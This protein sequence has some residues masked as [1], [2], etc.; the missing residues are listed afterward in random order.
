MAGNLLAIGFI[1]LLAMSAWVTLSAR[2]AAMARLRQQVQAQGFTIERVTPAAPNV[3][4]YLNDQ[5]GRSRY[6]SRSAF[7]VIVSD[8]GVHLKQVWMIENA[9]VVRI[10]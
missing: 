4:T 10:S 8:H 2:R 3:L 1:L 6:V 5:Y 7:D 9:R